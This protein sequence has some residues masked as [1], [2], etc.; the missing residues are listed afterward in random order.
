ML[1]DLSPVKIIWRMLM[2]MWEWGGVNACSQ[3][4]QL[5]SEYNLDPFFYVKWFQFQVQFSNL[6]LCSLHLRYACTRLIQDLAIVLSNS[7]FVKVC[8]VTFFWVCSVHVQLKLGA[9]GAQDLYCSAHR[10]SG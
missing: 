4:T 3:K 6:L 5:D 1:W 7:S 8:A 10:I 9:R 2:C